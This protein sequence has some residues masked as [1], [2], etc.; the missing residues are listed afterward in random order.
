MG[1]SFGPINGNGAKISIAQMGASSDST[2]QLMIESERRV[3]ADRAQWLGD[4]DFVQV[5]IGPLLDSTYIK[6]RIS[7]IN[8]AKATLS[9][10][11]SAGQFAGYESPETTHYSIVDAA[12]NAVSITT[13][14][15]N[16][17]GSKVFVGGAGFL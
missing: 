1:N 9:S 11:I 10:E 6:N 2:V 7:S 15:N 13:T 12:G 5:P 14:L 16:S 8:F 17:F 3:F 4:P